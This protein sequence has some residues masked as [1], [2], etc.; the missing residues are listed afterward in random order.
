M[1]GPL[2]L[3]RIDFQLYPYILGG[4]GVLGLD[5][6]SRYRIQVVP[7]ER[8]ALRPRGDMWESAP[9]RIARWPWTRACPSVGCLR[10]RLEP[11]GNDARLVFSFEVDLPH[12]VTMLLGCREADP[13]GSHVP[14]VCERVTTGRFI[15]TLALRSTNHVLLR[16]ASAVK[17]QTLEAMVPGGNRWLSRTGCREISVLDVMPITMQRLPPTGDAVFADLTF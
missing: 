5:V 14:T 17:D 7:G 8:L 13:V 3:G 12:P 1:L 4:S 10:A 2:R 15:T 9:Q 11:A 6:L 16:V